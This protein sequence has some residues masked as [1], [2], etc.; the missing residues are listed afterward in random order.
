MAR[1]P[2]ED[3]DL[4]RTGDLVG[5]LRYMSPE[6]VRAERGGVGPATDV[7]S[8]GATL[9]ELLT[10]RPAFD[11]DDR[12]ELVRRI[13]DGE[14]TRPKRPKRIRPSIPRDLET[15]VLKAM[16]KEPAARYPSAA[17]RADDLRRFL[18]DQPIRAAARRRPRRPSRNPW[19]GT[20]AAAPPTGS[21]WPSSTIRPARRNR[22]VG[23]STR[24]PPGWNAT[25]TAAPS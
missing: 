11:A 2:Q 19:N 4:T 6:Q 22:P 1:R 20:T 10:L 5:T 21:S 13:L 17:T 8:L 16:E 15:I 9:Y 25:R 12:Q 23:D 18:D 7:Y 24:A 14:P 3:L